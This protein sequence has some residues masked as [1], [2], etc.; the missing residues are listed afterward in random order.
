MSG[1]GGA[2]VRGCV[3]L[4]GAGGIA[5]PAALALAAGGVR[6]IRVADDDEV[7]IT[8]LHR[9]ILFDADDVGRPKL[10][11]FAEALRRRHPTLR[12]DRR[13]GRFTPSAAAA[14][15]PGV[16]VVVDATD[17]FASRFLIADVCR[18]TRTP[19]VHAAA[20]R[21]RATVMAVAA[22]GRPCY[23]CLFEDL[24][25]GNA[26]DCATAGVAGPVCGVAGA[27][28]ADRALAILAGDASVYGRIATYDGL[29]DTL[30]S[31]PVAARP[32]CALCGERADIATIDASRYVI[33]CAA[34]GDRDNGSPTHVEGDR[35]SGSPTLVAGDR[36]NGAPTYVEGDRESGSP[37]HV[38]GD[39]GSGSP[40]HLNTGEHDHG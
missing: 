30:R 21:W 40:A 31:V 15:M 4:V 23:R 33:S 12:V 35:E 13:Y 16:S 28:A 11:A 19:V 1:G 39:R 9:Q 18:L 7:E 24:P 29:S 36:D 38:E 10:D 6:E 14:L 5:A 2:T 3:L 37:T 34:E 8:N 17:N 27:I 26:P 25:T 22:E 32:A 20:I